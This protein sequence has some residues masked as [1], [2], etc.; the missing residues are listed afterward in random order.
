MES[1]WL[2]PSKVRAGEHI[3]ARWFTTD[4]QNL[5]CSLVE[6][7]G[8]APLNLTATMPVAPHCDLTWASL[9]VATRWQT[10]AASAYTQYPAIRLRAEPDH[11]I[12]IRDSVHE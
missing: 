11:G 5:N 8:A 7:R 6:R 3:H 2:F 10:V 4:L 9:N 1:T 12:Y